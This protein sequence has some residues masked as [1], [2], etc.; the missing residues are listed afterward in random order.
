LLGPRKRKPRLF[1]A[2]GRLLASRVQLRQESPPF[3]TNS[4]KTELSFKGKGLIAGRRNEFGS[5]LNPTSRAGLSDL[6]LAC[7]NMVDL[8]SRTRP[9]QPGRWV[10]RM[11]MA[12][13]RPTQYPS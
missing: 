8:L 11:G 7:Y 10:F 5:E 6:G 12:Q 3:Y 1:A 2:I 4:M 9:H 13:S